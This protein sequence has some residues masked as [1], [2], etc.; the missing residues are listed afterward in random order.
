[1][2]VTETTFKIAAWDEETVSDLENGAKLTRARVKKVYSG[3][4]KGDGTV[5]YVMTHRSDGSAIFVGYESFLGILDGRTGSFVF[6][7]VGTF[8][9][10]AVK[11]TWTIAEG[12]ATGDLTGLSGSV[13]FSAGHQEEYPV[14]FTFDI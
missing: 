11:S 9:D 7:H 1:M 10:G 12:T 4:L 5:E 8:T 14:T 2:A 3:G 13:D 6:H